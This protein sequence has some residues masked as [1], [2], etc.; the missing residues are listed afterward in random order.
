LHQVEKD[1]ASMSP[2]GNK[3]LGRLHSA[4]NLVR[5]VAD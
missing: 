5:R 4:K 2:I 1:I 3:Q